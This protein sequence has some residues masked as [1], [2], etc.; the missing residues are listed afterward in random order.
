M[1][2][3]FQPSMYSGAGDYGAITTSQNG[4]PA[5]PIPSEIDIVTV[6]VRL[7]AGTRNIQVTKAA[8]AALVTFIEWWDKTIEPVTELGG[9]NYRPVRGYENV[10]SNHGS[11]S[12]VDINASKHPLG[13]RGTV[14]A[15]QAYLISSK[16]ASLGIKWGGNFSTRADEM[17]GEIA[18]GQTAATL[19]AIGGRVFAA[20][21]IIL[22]VVVVTTVGAAV[23]RRRHG[24]LDLEEAERHLTRYTPLDGRTSD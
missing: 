5:S 9:Y 16:A 13:A 10:I 7:K 22:S 23:Y 24:A 4:W 20:W 1:N 19:S 17:H 14:T 6:P 12:A 21:P 8:A 2:Q 3:V 11:G 15:K 18:S